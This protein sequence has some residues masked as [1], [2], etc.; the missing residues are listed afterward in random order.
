MLRKKTRAPGG[1]RKPLDPEV[2]QSV[3][4]MV[5]I[6]SNFRNELLALAAK[7]QPHTRQANLSAEIKRA[8]RYW[9]DRHQIWQAHN[10][11][12]GTA[13]AVLVDRIEGVSGKTWLDDAMTRELVRS[14]VVKLVCH[15]LTPLSKRVTIPAE[16]RKDADVVLTLLKAAI[17]RPGS[18][19]LGRPTVIID[20]QGLATILQDLGGWGLGEGR[21]NVE[22]R[23]ALV[24]RREREQDEQAWA[25]AVRTDTA[26]AFMN[27]VQKYSSGAHA[28][29][30][31]ERL[32]ALNEQ[33]GRK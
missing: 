3:K 5:R 27:Y 26:A 18:P 16:V 28:T 1:G 15:I 11:L 25:D 23:P 9:V 19:R 10:S 24:A 33:K 31:R 21:V 12:F 14:R 22:T 2:A 8:L 29:E 20:D 13:V 17:P 32:A 30:A 7:H 6:N 4:V